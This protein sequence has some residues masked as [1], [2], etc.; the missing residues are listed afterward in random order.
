MCGFVGFWHF[1]PFS[2][3]FLQDIPSLL[4]GMMDTIAHRGPDDSGMWWDASSGIALGHRRLSIQDISSAGHQPMM[5]LSKRFIVIYNGE[6]YNAPELRVELHKKGIPF[7]SH[8]DT[9]VLL[10]AWEHW[11]GKEAC[12]RFIGMFAFALWDQQERTLFLVRDRLGVKPLYWGTQ[13]NTL[14]FG[15]VLKSFM[16]HPHWQGVLSLNA[17]DNFIRFGYVPTPQSIFQNLHKLQPGSIVR[18]QHDQQKVQEFFWHLPQQSIAICSLEER[19]QELHELL[20]QSVKDRLLSDV[21]VGALLSG[22][23][24][25]SLVTAIMQSLSNTT[26]STFSIGFEEHAY[27]EADTAAQVARHLG[28][29]HTE[30]ILTLS[31]MGRCVPDLPLWYDEPFADSSQIPTYFVCRLARQKVSVVLSGDG[32]DELFAGYRRYMIA[33]QKWRLLKNLPYA[34]RRL[35]MHYAHPLIQL[36]FNAKTDMVKRALTA[37]NAQELYQ[38]CLTHTHQSWV[39][40]SS[41]FVWPYDYSHFQ[42]NA[43]TDLIG[44]FQAADMQGYLLDDILVKVDRASMAVGLEAR[45]PLLDHR[46]VGWSRQLPLSLRIHNGQGKWLLRQILYKYVPPALVDRPKQGFGIP[47]RALITETLR[48]WSQDLLSPQALADHDLFHTQAVLELVQDVFYQS[49]HENLLW[50]FLVFQQWFRCYRSKISL[51][52]R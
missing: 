8:S 23:I 41:E 24:D 13:G 21:P 36:F 32:G 17:L 44:S 35:L 52:S 4:S 9:E 43:Q 15:S 27:N 26:V 30:H 49:R 20:C 12:Q 14:F 51:P 38:A 47:L 34:L 22:G 3:T 39:K 28:T 18:I 33:A 48:E 40:G 42:K 45:E 25:S 7:Y 31:E 1:Q 5:S 2:G 11:G 29:H 50:H 6:I 37:R 16:P 10:A 46:L 19:K